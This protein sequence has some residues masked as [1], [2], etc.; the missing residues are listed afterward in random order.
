M[1]VFSVVLCILGG[2]VIGSAVTFAAM[3]IAFV[4]GESY[5]DKQ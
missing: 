5:E 2:A 1:S 4:A 3:A